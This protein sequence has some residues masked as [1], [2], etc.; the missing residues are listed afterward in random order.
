MKPSVDLFFHLAYSTH[1]LS[2]YNKTSSFKSLEKT[3][4]HSYN[5]KAI[6]TKRAQ[7]IALTYH[8]KKH[9]LDSPEAEDKVAFPI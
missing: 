5:R 3:F 7:C 8:I 6:Q 2:F 1:V 9:G 4:L